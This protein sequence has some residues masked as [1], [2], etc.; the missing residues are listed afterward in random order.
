MEEAVSSFLN[1]VKTRCPKVAAPDL[2]YLQ[3]G[4]TITELKPK[5]FYIRSNTV[6]KEIGFVFSGLLRA[7]YV[8]NNGQFYQRRE[9]RNTL[10]RFHLP[11]AL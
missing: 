9:I 3:T 10:F 1:S 11:D 5:D 7:F 6:Q 2:E 4:L 8:D